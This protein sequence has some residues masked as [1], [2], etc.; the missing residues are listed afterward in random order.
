MRPNF[1]IVLLIVVCSSAHSQQRGDIFNK[2]IKVTWLGLDFS[3]AKIIEDRERIGS[4]SD[5][6]RLIESWN[7]IFLKEPDKFN[8]ARAIGRENVMKSI[9]ITTDHNLQLDVMSL[10]SGNKEDYVHMKSTD[11]DEIIADYDFS[12]LSGIGLMFIVESFSRLNMEGAVWVTFVNLG[13]KEILFTERVTGKP[14][15]A[16]I[17]NNWANSV[18]DVLEKIQKKE[19]IKWRKL[20]TN[21]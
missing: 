9:D 4:E 11:V 5:M 3:K 1:L 14:G 16:G 19:F 2:D 8:V 7:T 21:S 15:G 6:H 20:Y 10:Y 18:F 17:R 13:S 12:G